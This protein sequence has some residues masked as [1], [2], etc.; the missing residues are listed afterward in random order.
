VAKSSQLG[1]VRWRGAALASGDGSEQCGG[2]QPVKGGAG[3]S[4]IKKI[5]ISEGLRDQSEKE[6]LN[7]QFFFVL[8]TDY[9]SL[10]IA[11]SY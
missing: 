5:C 2:L 4:D 10:F 3:D 9:R 6:T 8:Y 1:I 11:S 7:C